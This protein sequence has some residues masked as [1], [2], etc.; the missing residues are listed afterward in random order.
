MKPHAFKCADHL[1]IQN[2]LCKSYHLQIPFHESSY[3]QFKTSAQWVN[4]RVI[5]DRQQDYFGITDKFIFFS[6]FFVKV[7]VLFNEGLLQL[8]CKY[9]IVQC[10]WYSQYQYEYEHTIMIFP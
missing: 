3:L 2:P 8:Y 5:S 7:N 4:V 1:Y 10:T 9:K 6:M